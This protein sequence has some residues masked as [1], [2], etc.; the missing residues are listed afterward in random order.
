MIGLPMNDGAIYKIADTPDE[1]SH[2]KVLFQ[3]YAQ[4]LDFD[5][6]F[7]SFN[8]ELNSIAVQYTNQQAPYF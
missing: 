1:F 6:A 2:G 8:E 5:L 4:S 3:N 7:Q